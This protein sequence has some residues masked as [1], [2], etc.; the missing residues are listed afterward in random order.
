MKS[1]DLKLGDKIQIEE[2]PPLP[3]L[4]SVTMSVSCLT[5][6]LDVLLEETFF[7]KILL[8]YH[9]NKAISPTSRILLS[10]LFSVLQADVTD[11]SPDQGIL[12]EET[13]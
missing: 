4:Q 8:M 6:Y 10:C 7:T 5:D 2:I 12:S 3:V 13:K 11:C 9:A 1:L